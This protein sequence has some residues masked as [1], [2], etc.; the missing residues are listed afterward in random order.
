MEA[1]KIP[2]SSTRK[3]DILSWLKEKGEVI[4]KPMTIPQLLEILHRIKPMQDKY[5]IDELA[6]EHDRTILRL[7]LY[8]CK[9]NSIDLA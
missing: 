5:V 4:N 3:A 8:H 7:P 2:N 1:D 9:L 6:K